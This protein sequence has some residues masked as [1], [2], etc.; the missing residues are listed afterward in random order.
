MITNYKC[1]KTVFLLSAVL[2]ILSSCDPASSIR[3]IIVNKTTKPLNVEYQF[4]G[5]LLPHTDSIAANSSMTVN[6]EKRVDDVD[7]INKRLGSISFD[8]LILK[9][10]DKLSHVNLKNKKYWIFKKDNERI[11]T[12]TLIVD[13]SFFN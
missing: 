3:Y 9:Q 10:S 1:L 13:K 8:I 12:Y 6:E 2:F 7:E 4:P 5:G 11:A